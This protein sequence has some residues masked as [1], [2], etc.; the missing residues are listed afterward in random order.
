MK[1]GA[2]IAL[3]IGTGVTVLFGVF[4]MLYGFNKNVH[5]WV[6]KQ[7]GRDDTSNKIQI[8]LDKTT[9]ELKR[10]S[11]ADLPN[12]SFT[13][14]VVKGTVSYPDARLRLEVDRSHAGSA[15]NSDISADT[16]HTKIDTDPAS[17]FA[18][19][20]YIPGVTFTVTAGSTLDDLK[21]WTGYSIYRVYLESDD[22]VKA[23]FVVNYVAV[24]STTP[25]STSTTPATSSAA[26]N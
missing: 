25:A 2:S 23:E 4:G 3:S 20:Y 10:S 18:G 9:A 1:K 19:T 21:N 24:D 13:A 15:A 6:D 26:S 22:K 12:V 14:D 16:A 17:S 5:T 8:K 7:L 11:I